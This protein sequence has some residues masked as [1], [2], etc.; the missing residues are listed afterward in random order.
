MCGNLSL[1]RQLHPPDEKLRRLFCAASCT[2]L[3]PLVPLL[4]LLAAGPPRMCCG[5]GAGCGT[6]KKPSASS[7]SSKLQAG[8]GTTKSGAEQQPCTVQ[9]R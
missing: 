4:V 3:T 6:L 7:N 8:N 1:L 2:P 9:L 5:G